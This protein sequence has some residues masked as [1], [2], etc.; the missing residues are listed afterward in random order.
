MNKNSRSSLPET[1]TINGTT[2]HEKQVIADNFNRFFAS[3]GEMNE[4]NTVEHMDSSYTAD[5]LTN[6]IDSNFAFRLID[7]RYTLSI[8]SLISM[9]GY[10]GG[11]DG[12]GSSHN[13]K[14]I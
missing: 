3:I 4:T 1:M 7:N 13:L 12:E 6:Q 14:C 10:R 9:F 2:C 8:S 11:L 5:Y